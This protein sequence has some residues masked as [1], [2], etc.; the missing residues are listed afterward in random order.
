MRV[1]A[2]GNMP[3]QGLVKPP[4]KPVVMIARCNLH[5]WK[6]SHGCRRA[7]QNKNGVD[8][9]QY[10]R[11]HPLDFYRNAKKTAPSER[12]LSS[13]TRLKLSYSI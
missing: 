1:S 11:M 8:M 13:E 9:K 12:K 7:K 3:L 10:G 5:R 6:G 4:A 2:A